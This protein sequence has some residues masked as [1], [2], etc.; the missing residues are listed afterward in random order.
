MKLSRWTF[1]SACAITTIIFILFLSGCGGGGKT[2]QTMD[3]PYTGDLYGVET[4]PTNQE[5]DIAVD[6]WIHVYWPHT[7]YPPPETF[8]VK[9][10]KE[11]STNQWGAIHTVQD[12]KSSDSTNGSWWFAPVNNF[13]TDTWYRIVITDD[14][15]RTAISYFKTTSS[16]K[17]IIDNL[18][19]YKPANTNNPT[20]EDLIEHSIKTR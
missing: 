2:T 12:D 4:E 3:S 7:D 13:S 19:T 16:S 11:E 5:T 14:S 18:K 8:T 20:G 15:G 9:V 6:S 1:N 17:G 10:E